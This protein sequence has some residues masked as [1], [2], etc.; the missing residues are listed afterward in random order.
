MVPR[1]RYEGCGT[2]PPVQNG[3]CGVVFVL[4]QLAPREHAPR[5]SR[6]QCVQRSPG[7]HVRPVQSADAT[8]IHQASSAPQAPRRRPQARYL[9]R[10]DAHV[11]GL[12]GAECSDNNDVRRLRRRSSRRQR[13]VADHSTPHGRCDAGSLS[14]WHLRNRSFESC[15]APWQGV[16]CVYGIEDNHRA[17]VPC[18]R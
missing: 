4:V 8:D 2:L 14:Q 3:C 5:V 7:Y 17:T 12:R 16:I 11:H 9:C 15:K 18:H 6:V 1:P 10:H 13:K